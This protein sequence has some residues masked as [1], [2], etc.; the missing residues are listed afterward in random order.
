MGATLGVSVDTDDG[1]CVGVADGTDVDGTRVGIEVGVPLGDSVRVA[2]GATD[3][4]LDGTHVGAPVG[5]VV[6]VVDGTVDGGKL[7]FEVGDV[8]GTLVGI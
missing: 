6:G 3:G 1:L 8:V 5:D 4:E 2:D 7:G